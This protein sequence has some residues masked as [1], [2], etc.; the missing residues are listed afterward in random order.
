[1]ADT[2]DSK[3]PAPK[4][5]GFEPRPRHQSPRPTMIP[6]TTF[7]TV[8]GSPGARV[9]VLGLA[10]TYGPFLAALFVAGWL[11]H[12]A[13]PVPIPPVNPMAYI[14]RPNRV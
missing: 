8:H 1:M 6:E 9:R 14:L 12:A 4:A 7:A 10:A 2:G 11:L 3:S 5:C 13:L